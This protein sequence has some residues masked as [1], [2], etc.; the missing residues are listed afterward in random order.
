MK[1]LLEAQLPL[2]PLEE[3]TRIVAQIAARRCEISQVRDD[4][5]KQ[6]RNLHSLKNVIIHQLFDPVNKPKVRLDVVLLHQTQGI[7]EK[8]AEYPVY[9]ATRGGIA[10]AKEKVGKHGRRYKPVRPSTIFYNPMRILL[11]SIGI[12]PENGQTGITSPDYVVV[13]TKPG[14]LDPAVFYEWFRGPY[15]GRMILDLARGAVRERILFSRLAEGTIALPAFEDQV[16][17]SKAIAEANISISK[18][19]AQDRDLASLDKA[20]LQEAFA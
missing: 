2:P 10:L 18:I 11:G 12:L 5:T 7:G 1:D 4:I 20:I 6:R 9:G 8:W 15:G 16:V 3:Q 19:G 14:V 17:A 13:N